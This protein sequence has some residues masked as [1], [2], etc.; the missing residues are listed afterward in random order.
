VRA[1]VQRLKGK[2]VFLDVWGTWCG[3]CKEEIKHLPSLRAAFPGDEVAFL[4]LAMDDDSRHAIWKDFI[5]ANAMVGLHFRKTR[6]TIPPF[7]NELLG[8]HPAKSQS[9]PQYFL[10]DKSGKLAIAKARHPSEGE[11]LYQQIREVLNKAD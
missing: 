8:Q 1:V 9:Y 10:F 2:V 4:F 3:P 5:R 7:G 6:Q 11:A